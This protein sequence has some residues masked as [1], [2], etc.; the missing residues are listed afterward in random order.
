MIYFD[1]PTQQRVIESLVAHLEPEG[2]LFIGHSEA[3]TLNEPSLVP[4]R[5]AIFQKAFGSTL[6][7]PHRESALLGN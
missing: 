6:G 1:P 4:I 2:F 5:P 7:A 3:M